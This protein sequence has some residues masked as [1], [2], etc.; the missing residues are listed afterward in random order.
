MMPYT[1]AQSA[2]LKAARTG[3]RRPGKYFNRKTIA[4]GKEFDS[5]K[6]A[7]QYHIFSVLLATNAI[8]N[9][10]MQVQYELIPKT[11]KFRACYYIADFVVEQNDGRID[12]I[13]VK[14]DFTRTLPVYALKKK[15]MYWRHG[16]LIQER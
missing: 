14:S 8:K 2:I 13:D 16:I 5:R 7:S 12:V 9:L 4:G 11:D 15:L 3:K 1:R 6:E 10:K